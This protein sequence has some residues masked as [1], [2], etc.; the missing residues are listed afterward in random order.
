MSILVTGSIAIDHIMVFQD[1]FRNHILAD[2]I[3]TLNVAFHVPSLRKSWG[4]TGGNIAFGLRRLEEDPLLLGAVGSDFETYAD[5][6]DRHGVRRDY[7]LALEDSFTA[8]AFITTDLDDNQITAFHS[9]AMDRAHEAR[10]DSVDTPFSIGI[11][12]PNGKRAMQEYARE[13]KG[14][15]VTTVID[16]GQGL[17]LFEREELIELLDGASIYI[18]NDYEWSLTLEKTGLGEAEVA[19]RVETIVI[20]RGEQGSSIRTGEEGFEIPVVA[21]DRVVD[22][23]GCGDAYRAG[24]LLGVLRELPLETCGRLGSVLGS[25]AV[26]RE[27]TQSPHTHLEAVKA[28]FEREFGASF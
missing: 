22:P 7:V 17:P 27:G 13:L 28:R 24:F 5:W 21:P 16:P 2:R 20:T 9:G 12:A 4:G 25:L 3:H 14:L 23:T 8:Q 26:E 10:I 11:V 6:L 19:R 18:V 15:G 1:R